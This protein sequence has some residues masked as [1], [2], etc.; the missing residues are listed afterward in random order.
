MNERL[1]ELKIRVLKEKN[2]KSL[3]RREIAKMLSTKIKE[4]KI[5]K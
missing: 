4:E 3:I 5:K 1:K 2:K